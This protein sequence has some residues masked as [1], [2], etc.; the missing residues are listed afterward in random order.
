MPLNSE[1][2]Q[3]KSYLAKNRF[4]A[5]WEERHVDVRAFTAAVQYWIRGDKRDDLK[6]R[7]FLFPDG[8]VYVEPTEW[9]NK[10]DHYTEFNPR[11]QTFRLTGVRRALRIK[12]GTNYPPEDKMGGPYKLDIRP[13]PGDTGP[14]S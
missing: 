3:R 11:Y 12:G 7:V 2:E 13:L 5:Y 1:E 6:T 14:T 9:L 8:K 10:D 4:A